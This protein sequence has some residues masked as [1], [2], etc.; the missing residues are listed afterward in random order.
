MNRNHR[1]DPD[2]TREAS[3]AL[4]RDLRALHVRVEAE[5][6]GGAAQPAGEAVVVR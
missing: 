4:E 1:G 5:L 2:A 3:R 6:D